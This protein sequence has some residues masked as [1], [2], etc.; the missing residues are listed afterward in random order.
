MKKKKAN[1]TTRLRPAEDS[2][3][4]EVAFPSTP[5]CAVQAVVEQL[6][7]VRKDQPARDV[8]TREQECIVTAR[9]ATQTENQPK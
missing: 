9:V 2:D 7:R 6:D 1:Q 5:L 3:L 8:Q 4:A